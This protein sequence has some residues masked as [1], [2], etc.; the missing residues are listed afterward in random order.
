[1][2]PKDNN[3][4]NGITVEV[5]GKVIGKI[6]EWKPQKETP[7]KLTMPSIDFLPPIG[8]FDE[9]VKTIPLATSRTWYDVIKE[10]PFALNNWCLEH[11][12]EVPLELKAQLEL[13][14][15]KL[16]DPIPSECLQPVFQL[17]KDFR[18]SFDL[19]GNLDQKWVESWRI[20]KDDK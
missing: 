7:E 6:K 18:F 9:F 16:G 1:M 3:S 5:D 2:I 11:S 10:L 19:E 14:G 13:W 4:F 12:E 17:L 8:K 20:K 15:L